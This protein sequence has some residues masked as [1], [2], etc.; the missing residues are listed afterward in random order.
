MNK[1]KTFRLRMDKKLREQ[2]QRYADREDEGIA[3]VSA[4]RAIN[5][6]LEENK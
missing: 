5:Q 1:E 2:L 3:S 6:F 4:R